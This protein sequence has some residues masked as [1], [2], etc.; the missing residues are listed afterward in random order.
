DGKGGKYINSPETPLYTKGEVLFGLHEGRVEIRRRGW[1]LLC[2]GNFDLLMLHQ[3]GFANAVAPLGTALTPA[4]AELLRRSAERVVLLFDGD[5]AGARAV[6]AAHPILAKAG[7]PAK[8]VTLPP[9][10]D[11]DSFLRAQ[12]AEALQQRVDGAP[13]IVEHLVEDAAARARDDAAGK[14]EAIAELGPVLTLVTS[15]IER[16]LHLERIGRAFGIRDVEAIKEQLRRGARAG[17]TRNRRAESQPRREAAAAPAPRRRIPPP[18][19]IELAV[20]GALLDAPELLAS[21]AAEVQDLLT[22][23]D[24][25]AIL[26]DASRQVVERGRVEAAALLEMAEENGAVGWLE[27]RLVVQRYDAPQAAEL[28][29]EALPRL[30][31]NIREQRARALRREILEAR[32]LGDHERANA[33]SREQMAVLRGDAAQGEADTTTS[34]DSPDEPSEAGLR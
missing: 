9:G 32:R 8:V 6:R 25:R 12:G 5:A 20:V 7:L 15:P 18:P 31:K 33:L 14:A 19:R 27:R 23:P 17:R 3:A 26:R 30:R 16:Q 10:E 21:R 24:L 11:P 13:G 22:S 1:A 4:Q 28:L 29:D 34:D 2:E